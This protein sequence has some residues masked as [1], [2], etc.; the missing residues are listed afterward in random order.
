MTE[1]PV[2]STRDMLHFSDG[3]LAYAGHFLHE[4]VQPVH[5]HSFVEVA[6]VTGDRKSVV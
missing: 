5:T 2:E 3:S 4:G 6:V 1:P